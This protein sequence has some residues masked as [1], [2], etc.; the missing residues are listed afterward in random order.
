MARRS[1][2]SLAVLNQGYASQAD[3]ALKECTKN[4]EETRHDVADGFLWYDFDPSR[5]SCK[6]AM[7]A[8]Q[9]AI[10]LDRK[11]LSDPKKQVTASEVGRLYLPTTMSLGADKTNKG[12]TYPEYDR[13][14][15]GGVEADHLVISFIAGRL[16]H[17]HK[18]A[19]DDGGYYEW[20]S[21]LYVLFAEHPGFHLTRTEPE[22][23]LTSTT[24]AG[25]HID[26][27]KFQDFINWTLDD[28]GWPTGLDAAG[29]KQLALQMGK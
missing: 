7:T 29:K 12:T 20:L 4:D 13:L 6:K 21:T 24:V 9:K 28:K 14:F 26:N 17:E 19:A 10:D 2:L 11:K 15:S 3:R 5:A 25:R 18:E 16:D 22:E 1:A 27:L 23:D 8:E